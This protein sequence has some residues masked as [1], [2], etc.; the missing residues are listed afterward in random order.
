[1]SKECR[2]DDPNALDRAVLPGVLH[3]LKATIFALFDLG[4]VTRSDSI[5]YLPPRPKGDDSERRH[6]PLRFP[7]LE[8]MRLRRLGSPTRRRRFCA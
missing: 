3:G 4:K 5:E 2:R 8:S 6:R 1:M 7:P